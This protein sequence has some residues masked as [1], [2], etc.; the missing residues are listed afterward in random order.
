[1]KNPWAYD[2]TGDT[3]SQL[4]HFDTYDID[5]PTLGDH[6]IAFSDGGDLYVYDIK[7]KTLRHIAVEV[8]LDGSHTQPK[9]VQAADQVDSESPDNATGD[10]GA[11][12][13]LDETSGRYYLK[14]IYIGD[15]TVPGYTAPLAQPGLK[16]KTGDF[17]LAINGQP[18][19]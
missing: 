16:V 9:W 4:T 14:H 12:L 17:V 8:L 15:N 6:R 7:N 5:F 19:K 2:Q 11:D 3:F 18:L 1:M 10:L 13:A